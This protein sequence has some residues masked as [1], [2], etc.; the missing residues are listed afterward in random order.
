[1]ESDKKYPKIAE[2]MQILLTK[3][4]SK[5]EV[6]R[7]LRTNA[8]SV[9]QWETG[10]RFINDP[11]MMEKIAFECG[12]PLGWLLDS[13][14]P[15]LGD[16]TSSFPSGPRFSIKPRQRIP[17]ISYASAGPGSGIEWEDAYP[18]GSG[19]E[20]IEAPSYLKDENGYALR[21]SGDSM[22]PKYTEG[23]IV[24]VSPQTEPVNNDFI[25]ARLRDGQVLLKRLRLTNGTVIL[26][27]VNPSYDPVI[28]HRHDIISMSKVVG[29][30]ER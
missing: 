10:N 14:A 27:S 18:V 3:Y 5:A 9:S 30:Q 23:M 20:M 19:M 1:M 13:G 6:A 17:L 26:E 2:A 28:V 12:K 4:G 21:V 16:V 7:A 8:T 24:F 11:G 29:S 15:R 22:S 25:V